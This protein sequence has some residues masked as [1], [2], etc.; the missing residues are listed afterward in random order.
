M[1]DSQSSSRIIGLF[2]DNR[3]LLAL[4]TVITIVAGLSALS[5]LPRQEDPVITNRGATILTVFPGASADRVEALVTEKIEN[6]LD[7]IETIKAFDPETQLST[8]TLNRV[9]LAPVSEILFNEQ[10]LGL[11]R[12]RYLAEL[13]SPVGDPMY[14][15]ARAEIR[16]GG[17]EGWLPLFHSHLD[18]IFDYVGANALIGALELGPAAS[19]AQQAA[20][21]NKTEIGRKF[22]ESY[23]L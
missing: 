15:A 21:K 2:F 11:F 23:K 20:D 12:E 9:A 18:T 17:I 8:R 4:F 3:Y 7:E 5:S 22:A 19:I 1:S 13:G 6:E 10:T 16:R 14:E